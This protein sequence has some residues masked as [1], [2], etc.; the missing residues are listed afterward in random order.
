M[1]CV[2]KLTSHHEI[3]TAST[4]R[5]DMNRFGE[6]PASAIF[7]SQDRLPTAHFR[8]SSWSM[9]TLNHTT[10]DTRTSR[11]RLVSH[12]HLTSVQ[13]VTYSRKFLAPR[14]NSSFAVAIPSPMFE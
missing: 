6:S 10:L 2:G 13:K 5:P 1:G 11:L 3:R 4:R 7:S 9:K 8:S 14:V 12:G